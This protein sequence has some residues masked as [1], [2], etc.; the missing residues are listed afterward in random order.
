M[1]LDKLASRNIS[2]I[3]LLIIALAI[4]L[5]LRNR[6]P[7]G[8]DQ[9]SFAS[10]PQ[11]EI[12]R[13]ELSGED[14]KL[15]LEKKGDTWMVNGRNEARRSA[16]SFIE[17]IL[18]EIKIKSPVSPDL[19]QQ[20]VAS[21]HIDPVR[22]RVFENSKLLSS[23]LVYKTGSNIYGNFMK[24]KEKSKPFIVFVP[25]YEGDIGSGFTM[26]ELFW[27]PYTVFNLL[28]S[29]I[30]FVSFENVAD[31]SS[32]FI[33][34]GRN[35][36]YTLSY[37]NTTRLGWD[38][39]RVSR[40]ISYFTLIPFESWALDLSQAEADS[41]KSESPLCRITVKK[42]DGTNILLTLWEKTNW[43]TGEKDSDRLWG[44]TNLRDEIFIMRYYDIDPL[45]KKRSYFYAQ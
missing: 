34:D 40:Y 3:I 41:I 13:I 9:A 28:P 8:K 33:I 18:T 27:L 42:S 45:L 21:K 23:F 15:S 43:E 19:F 16:I 26:N 38:S 22:V 32:S 7:F 31:P 1:I 5:L 12:T 14:Q 25:G 29:E 30:S 24:I 39:S 37:G 2:L 10:V 44:M 20:E 11:K 4:V 6:T 17:R 35:N 36:V